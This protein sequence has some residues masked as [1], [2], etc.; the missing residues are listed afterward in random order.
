MHMQLLAWLKQKIPSFPS[1]TLNLIL[2]REKPAGKILNLPA[3]KDWKETR[4]LSRL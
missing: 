2:R 4:H 3:K 1:L